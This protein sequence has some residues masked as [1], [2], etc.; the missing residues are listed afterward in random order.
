[1]VIPNPFRIDH[2]DRSSP[3][4]PEAMTLAPVNPCLAGR[5][6]FRTFREA[7]FL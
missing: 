3:A 2:E 5:Q 1:M 4:D 7:Q 6:A